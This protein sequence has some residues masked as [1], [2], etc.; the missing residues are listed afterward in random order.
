MGRFDEVDALAARA[1]E[2]EQPGLL[3]F[4]GGLARTTALLMKGSL[5]QARSLAEQYTD[6]AELQQPGR[7]IGEVLVAHVAIAQGDFDTAVAL[8]ATAAEVLEPT[9]YSWGPLALMLLAGALG[10]RGD[11]TG[12]AKALSHAE[13]RHGMKSALFA[14]ELALAR[15]WTRSAARDREGA[16]SAAREAARTAERGGQPA[17]ALR[18][19]HDAVRLGDTGDV[20]RIIRLARELDCA[21]G[22]LTLAH[23]LALASRD[24][25]TL[26]AVAAQLD[27]AGLHPAAADASLQAQRCGGRPVR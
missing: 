2:A 22:R 18:A 1:L 25:A 4:T 13:P 14:P 19:L 9:G 23:G 27:D 5:P 26:E 20:D 3:R 7:A 15:A 17:V 6:F 24:G 8:L 12:A 11:A 10:Q 21:Y 16:I